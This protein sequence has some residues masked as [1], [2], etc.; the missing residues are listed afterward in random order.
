[1]FDAFIRLRHE[2]VMCT[3][4]LTK[5]FLDPKLHFMKKKHCGGFSYL[6]PEVPIW[7][8]CEA[9]SKILC[10]ATRPKRSSCYKSVI[11]SFHTCALNQD[12]YSRNH[13]KSQAKLSRFDH[14][15]YKFIELRVQNQ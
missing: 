4:K 7:H 13:P 11:P 6:R 2:G 5:A 1:M 8:C 15:I 14:I 3:N 9:R 10:S 12:C